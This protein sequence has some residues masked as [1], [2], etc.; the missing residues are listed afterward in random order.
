MELQQ[1]LTA[2]LTAEQLHARMRERQTLANQRLGFDPQQRAAFIR[3]TAPESIPEILRRADQ[4]RAGMLLLPGTG[5]KLQF[6]GNPP[7]W[8]HNPT[9]DEEYIWQLSRMDHWATLLQAHVLS[10]EPAYAQKVVAE[11]A[12]WIAACPRPPIDTDPSAARRDF[13]AVTPWRSLEAGIR[14]Y[15]SWPQVFSYLLATD[16][17]TP[18]L[19][20]RMVISMHEHGRVLAEICPV[21][22]PRADHNHYLMENLGLLSIAV[23][24]PE[25]AEAQAWFEHAVRELERCAAAQLTVEGGQ[26]EGCPDYHNGCVY[27]FCLA[28]RIA[29]AR[30]PAAPSPFSADYTRRV[31]RSLDFTVHTM[32]P[33]GVSVPWGDS[34]ATDTAS[35]AALW[36][37]DSS[38]DAAALRAVAQLTGQTHARAK[39]LGLAWALRDPA[40]ALRALDSPPAS[41]PARVYWAKELDQVVL[42]SAWN[43][44]ALSLFF[45][46]RSPVNNGHSHID[47]AGFDFVA[48]DQAMIV[49][50][51][52]Y[53]YRNCPER[54]QMKSATA[55]NCLTVDRRE[56]FEYRD[57]W[58]FGPQQPG[59]I[60]HVWQTPRLLAAAAIQHN[61]QPAVHRRLVALIDERCLLVLDEL[62]SLRP[63]SSVQLYFHADTT[64]VQ[65]LAPGVSA[66]AT[67]TD[68]TASFAFASTAG[69][70]TGQTLPG[71]VSAIFDTW[72]DSSRLLLED[73]PPAAG[74]P[75]RLYATLILPARKT[76]APVPIANL[77]IHAT[78]SVIH[79][80][81]AIG[82]RPYHL[83]WTESTATLEQSPSI[84]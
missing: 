74:N 70:L 34:D 78:A 75:H 11:L 36:W 25:L 31:A 52:R 69:S 24:V 76:D 28:L 15:Q 49:D 67:F 65:W 64:D 17:F 59:R 21:F 54:Q 33:T 48:L 43:R 13:Y 10:G 39:V 40:Q 60:T 50:P 84:V 6:V 47:P 20:A 51:G 27:W 62:T 56:P 16:F 61:F 5:G 68:T 41:A 8:H 4:A 35:Q 3:A 71:K 44:Q 23:L 2:P 58:N 26:V 14:M 72:R 63:D 37:Y 19:L 42:H 18:D 32:R 30:D 1:I 79:C 73:A 66:H 53:T 46:C 83:T 81:F 80:T 9:T 57:S 38:G 82:T 45:A 55:H 29:G 12:D 7:A 77:R 22:W